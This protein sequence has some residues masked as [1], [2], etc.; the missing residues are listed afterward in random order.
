MAPYRLNS[1][2]RHFG[3]DNVNRSVLTSSEPVDTQNRVDRPLPSLGSS[4]PSKSVIFRLGGPLG[5]RISGVAPVGF[6]HH[7]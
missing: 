3:L 1:S 4:V 6:P 5:A 7:S 2:V